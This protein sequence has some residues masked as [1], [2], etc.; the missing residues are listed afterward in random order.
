MT[1]E[2]LTAELYQLTDADVIALLNH[3]ERSARA[4]LARQ[5]EVIAEIASR[6]VTSAFGYRDMP[7]LLRD[8]L[9]I[10]RGDARR[11]TRRAHSACSVAGLGGAVVPPALEH[12]APSFHSGGI[13]ASHLD[14][15][16]DVLA[17]LP[18]CIT[19]EQRAEHERTLTTLA[20]AA[21][22]AAVRAAGRHILTL[23]D[24][25]VP[26]DEKTPAKPRRELRLEWNR[27]G[28]ELKLSG[29]LDKES[30]LRL[31]VLL[32]P[33]AEPRSGEEGHPD[34]R[35]AAERSGDALADLL[36]FTERSAALPHAAGEPPHVVVTMTIA[37]LLGRSTAPA[38]LNH[39][40][41]IPAADARRIACDAKLIPAVLG[42]QSE[43]L[44]LGRTRR[45]SSVPQRRALGIRDGGCVFPG[46]T[47]TAAWCHA[48]HMDEWAEDDGPTDLKNLALVC[49][50]HHRLVHDSEWELRMGADGH[51]EAIPPKWLDPQQTPRRNE[52]H[53]I[54]QRPA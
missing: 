23:A 29:R 20:H 9:N 36:D 51:P 26:P 18:P 13:S 46:C 35:T 45:T 54:R 47:R 30:G 38:Y 10:D 32:S 40:H 43:V 22:P 31:Q 50:Y 34:T 41:P 28:D 14:A 33:L 53:R 24:Q 21:D 37:Q 19:L 27:K 6:G 15:I 8:V 12:A 25:D 16:D 4:A 11:R 44:D 1:G 48:H 39:E 42:T 5:A 17:A 49:P 52:Y 7:G 3:Y 2:D